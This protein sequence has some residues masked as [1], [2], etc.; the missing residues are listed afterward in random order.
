MSPLGQYRPLQ[1]L[2]LGKLAR[3]VWAGKA[4]FPAAEAAGG[5]VLVWQR[6]LG[7]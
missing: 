5:V 4:G 6:V 2:T 7:G 3:K 1:G